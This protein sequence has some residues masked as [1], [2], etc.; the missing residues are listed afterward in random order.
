MREILKNMREVRLIT[1]RDYS[2]I[3]IVE[4]QGKYYCK[5]VLRPDSRWGMEDII[6][7]YKIYD[8]LKDKTGLVRVVDHYEVSPRGEYHIIMEYLEGFTRLEFNNFTHRVQ[9]IRAIEDRLVGQGV[10]QLDMVPINFMVKGKD[11]AMIDLDKLYRLPNMFYPP[12]GP[13]QAFTWYGYAIA[14]T[15]LW[16]LNQG[17]AMRQ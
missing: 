15:S 17:K 2:E 8:T 5:K 14:R 6:R 4:S 12:P 13:D 3:Y 11:I 1:R 16:R 10:I 7:S 9:D